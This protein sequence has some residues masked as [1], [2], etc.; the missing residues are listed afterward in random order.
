MNRTSK[1]LAIT[2]LGAFLALPATADVVNV[3]Q[4]GSTSSVCGA[5]TALDANGNCIAGTATPTWIN[6]FTGN[7]GDTATL[8]IIAEGIDNGSGGE[9]DG[10]Y[11]NGT[12]VGNLTQQTFYSPL[13]N[14]SNSNA[15]SGPLDLDGSAGDPCVTAPTPEPCNTQITDLSV[16]TFDVTGLVHNGA[17]TIE[18]KVDPANWVNEIDTASLTGV[19]EPSSLVSLFFAA[20]LLGTILRKRLIRNNSI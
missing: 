13:F 2:V 12:F 11:V 17:N 10:V 6:N 19:P 15:I 1:I 3:Y 8:T 20:G 5:N 4:I 14:L 9:V 18:V 16:S 7:L